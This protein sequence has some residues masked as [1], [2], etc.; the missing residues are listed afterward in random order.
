M[1]EPN[2]TALSK[3]SPEKLAALSDELKAA[4]CLLSEADQQFFAG[5]FS[6]ASLPGVL[7]KKADLMKSNQVHAEQYKL[8]ME[9]ISASVPAA[10]A[11]SA[12][13]ENVMLGMASALGIGAVAVAAVTDNTAFYDG[14]TPSAL[15][16]ALRAE[17]QN[18]ATSFGVAGDDAS[19]T[20]TIA[21]QHDGQ[22]IPAMTINLTRLNDGAEIKVNDLAASG[23]LETIKSGGEKLIGFAGRGLNLLNRKRNGNLSVEDAIAAANETLDTGAGLA[24]AAN[25]LNLKQRAWKVIRPV[26]ESLE[27]QARAEKDAALARRMALEKLW[28]NYRACPTC[29]VAFSADENTCRVCGTAR[30]AMPLNADPRA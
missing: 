4:F 10:T 11:A 6:A 30:P 3:L 22:Q 24:E 1:T 13:G 18:Q 23:L 25:N 9:K 7:S 17:F 2:T 8:L 12:G 16:P 15:I 5:T 28:D 20:A 21:I 26:A 29:G 19:L 14:V 27:A